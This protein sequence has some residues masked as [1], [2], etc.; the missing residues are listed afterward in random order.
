MPD[1]PKTTPTTRAVYAV[2]VALAAA[3]IVSSTVQIARAVFGG[4]AADRRAEGSAPA[5]P[6]ACA[7]GLE[8]LTT[9]VDRAVA[10]AASAADPADAERRY[11]SARSPEWDEDRRK[12]L[13]APCAADPRGAEAV[14]AVARLDRAAEGAVRRQSGDLGPVRRAALSFIR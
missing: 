14:A 9:A 8:T 2:F 12:A 11:R 3:F 10:A 5:L 13:E 6:A 4:S 1:R 7:S